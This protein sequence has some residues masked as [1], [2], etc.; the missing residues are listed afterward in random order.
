[1]SRRLIRRCITTGVLAFA[2]CLAATTLLP[3]PAMAQQQD[4]LTRKIKFKVAP[5]YPEVARRLSI[6]GV[7]KIAVVVAPNGSLKSSKV[8]GGHPLLVNA[9]L[10][11]L[12]KWK[13]EPAPEESSGVVEFKFEP[14]D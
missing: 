3:A 7:V 11:A 1:V 12:K 5:A 2:T 13:F 6:S 10:D 9:A 8:V 4:E 14:Q